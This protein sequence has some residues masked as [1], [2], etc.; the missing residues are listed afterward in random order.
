M[1]YIDNNNY[2]VI[3]FKKLDPYAELGSCLL[4]GL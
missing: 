2:G 1:V 3:F 4:D